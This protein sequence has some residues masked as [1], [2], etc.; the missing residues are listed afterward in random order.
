MIPP[1]EQRPRV[2]KLMKQMA[3]GGYKQINVAEWDF[4]AEESGTETDIQGTEP[5]T[6]PNSPGATEDEN[7]GTVNTIGE[8]RLSRFT[9]EQEPPPSSSPTSPAPNCAS[10]ADSDKTASGEVG[11]EGNDEE[12]GVRKG[13]FSVLE[14][15]RDNPSPHLEETPTPT[16]SI[17]GEEDGRRSRFK[18]ETSTVPHES[19]RVASPVAANGSRFHVSQ[20]LQGGGGGRTDHHRADHH[21]VDRHNVDRHSVDHVPPPFNT[22]VPYHTG[23]HHIYD[24]DNYPPPTSYPPPIFVHPSQIDQ[25]LLLNELIRQQL[26]ELRNTTTGRSARTTGLEN[27]YASTSYHPTI[28]AGSYEESPQNPYWE[29]RMRGPMVEDPHVAFP[30]HISS[31]SPA[32]EMWP[33]HPEVPS[34]FT[35]PDTRSTATD[36]RIFSKRRSM[37]IDYR[38]LYGTDPRLSNLTQPRPTSTLAGRHSNLLPRSPTGNPL[39]DGGLDNLKRELE[40]LRRENDQLRSKN[41]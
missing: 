41:V 27:M 20:P 35:R 30:P 15:A 17:D 31:Y 13:R 1:L 32:Y 3:E 36:P 2:T 18:V 34:N 29:P 6:A 12:S 23:Q 10:P 11:I 38:S 33:S 16:R 26:V 19:P 8:M 37:S 24:N 25:L 28:H 9:V 39:A 21:G 14:S 40:T 4:S 22:D 5:S 7:G